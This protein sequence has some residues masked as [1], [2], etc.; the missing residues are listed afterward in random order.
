MENNDVFKILDFYTYDDFYEYGYY[1]LE[2]Q[3]ENVNHDGLLKKRTAT[4]LRT[5]ELLYCE[6]G[7]PYELS[8]LFAVNELYKYK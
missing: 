4:K 6:D 5:F 3:H 7:D 1:L 2:A 8:Q